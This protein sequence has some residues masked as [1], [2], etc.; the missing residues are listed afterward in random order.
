MSIEEDT[1]AFTAELALLME[2]Y[3]VELR[4][5]TTKHKVGKW[6][7]ELVV[8]AA[9]YGELYGSRSDIHITAKQTATRRGLIEPKNVRVAYAKKLM[10]VKE[11]DNE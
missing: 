3:E 4:V 11:Q 9:K 10:G 5:R 7:N 8:T 2:K 6:K 1:L